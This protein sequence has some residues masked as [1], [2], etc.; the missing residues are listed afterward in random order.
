M[1]A[2]EVIQAEPSVKQRNQ[3]NRRTSAAHMLDPQP[4]SCLLAWAAL[5]AAV[6]ILPRFY[7]CAI[8]RHIPQKRLAP[9]EVADF[10]CEAH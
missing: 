8:I 1:L 6:E 9:F 3:A 7:Q 5:P 10:V 2:E 4:L